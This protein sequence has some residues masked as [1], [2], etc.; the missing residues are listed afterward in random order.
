MSTLNDTV[1]Y[2]NHNHQ[3]TPWTSQW[4]CNATVTHNHYNQAGV[5]A[6]MSSLNITC[7]YGRVWPPTLTV[8]TLFVNK[9][10]K[11]SLNADY[12]IGNRAVHLYYGN[13]DVNQ[14]EITLFTSNNKTKGLK[15]THWNV[16]CITNK[17]DQIK[18]IL[19]D[20]KSQPHILDQTE[21]WLTDTYK[22]SYVKLP[23]YHHLPEH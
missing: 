22:D 20:T 19:R 18:Q 3:L 12:I 10:L 8:H 2:Y 11:V 4:I 17:M 16:Q 15:I 14:S 23:A 1:K 9:L 7:V 13:K 5:T 6:H 21:T